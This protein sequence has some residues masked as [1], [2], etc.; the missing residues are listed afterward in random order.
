MLALMLLGFYL[1]RSPFPAWLI[2]ISLAALGVIVYPFIADAS[3]VNFQVHNPE[4]LN[5]IFGA[6]VGFAACGL[7]AQYRHILEKFLP[8]NGE[9]KERTD[10]EKDTSVPPAVGGPGTPS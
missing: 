3:K 5:R 1:K 7:Q 10:N 8:V 9:S 4:V 2:P 6:L